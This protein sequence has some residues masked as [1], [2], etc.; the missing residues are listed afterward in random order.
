VT[1]PGARLGGSSSIV[2]RGALADGATNVLTT[3]N[4]S[5]A[6]FRYKQPLKL[7][8]GVAWLHERGA[9]E[10][11]LRYHASPG[12]YSVYSSTQE[13]SAIVS[14]R[15]GVVEE[16]RP[17]PDQTYTPRPVANV[18]VG[19]RFTVAES[20]TV[21]GGFFTDRSPVADGPQPVFFH[22][23]LIGATAGAS[24]KFRGLSGSV[25]IAYLRGRRRVSLPSQSD[26]GFSPEIAVD[27]IGLMYALSYTF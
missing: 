1:A 9:I 13:V 17:F 26:A 18:A 22:L 23:D 11:D 16:T 27:S 21:H 20:L 7:T 2:Y 12:S 10:V 6:T 3:F 24:L 8:A 15:D 4:D 19:G 14:G 5:R 25:G